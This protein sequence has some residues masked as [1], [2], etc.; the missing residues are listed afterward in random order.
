M[1]QFDHIFQ[2]GGNLNHQLGLYRQLLPFC[3]LVVVPT[4][5]TGKTPVEDL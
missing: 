5:G 1:I 4:L 2:M 3:S